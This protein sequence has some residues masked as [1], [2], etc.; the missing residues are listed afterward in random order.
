MATIPI[1]YLAILFCGIA[2][3]ALGFLWY[4][5]LFTK[6]W[7]KLSGVSAAS[8][9][10]GSAGKGYAI[11]FVG[12][13]VMAWVLAYSLVFA[14]TYLGIS[15]IRAGMQA[16]F[17]N[18]LGFVAPVTLGGVLWEDKSW[19]LWILN[20]GYNLTQLVLMGIILALWL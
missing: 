2:S 7:M 6:T 20:N 3:M 11:S 16:G 5:T 19:K 12:S 1:N 10:G 14:S 13:L 8:M 17:W 4:G 15:G 9:K 18:W